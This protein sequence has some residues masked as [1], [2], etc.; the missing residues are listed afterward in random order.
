MFQVRVRVTLDGV[1]KSIELERGK[2]SFGDLRTQVLAK[3]SITTSLAMRYTNA[4]G[5]IYEVG[6]DS[7]L[8][9]VLKDA[10]ES[11]ATALELKVTSQ[12]SHTGGS[13]YTP[14]S[15][16]TKAAGTPSTQSPSTAASNTPTRAASTSVGRSSSPASTSSPSSAAMPGNRTAQHSAPVAGEYHIVTWNIAGDASSINPKPKITYAQD[17]DTFSFWPL[18]CQHDA[19]TRVVL[20]DGSKLVFES[21]YTFE[22]VSFGGQ[23]GQSTAK[24]TQTVG[25]PI[26][27]STNLIEVSGHK[28]IIKH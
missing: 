10:S 2:E 1:T 28:I 23:K 22:D 19:E 15:T 12:P 11:R 14:T 6:N 24:V 25:L 9:R 5:E 20:Q 4:R 17:S 3:H 21:I 7:Q 16:P 26:K 8:E 18:P 13:S 27:V